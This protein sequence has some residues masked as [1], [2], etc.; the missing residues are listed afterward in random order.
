MKITISQIN[1]IIGDIDYNLKKILSEINKAK[2]NKSDV[3]LFPELCLCGYP[4]EDLIYF[5]G[6]TKKIQESLSQIVSTSQ[7]ILIVVGLVRK[8][9]NPNEKGFFNSAAVIAD[10]KLLGFKDKTLLPTYDVFNEKRYFEVGKDQKVFSYKGKKLGILICEDVWQHANLGGDIRY[11]RDPVEELKKLEP[12]V[13]LVLS[14]SPYYFKKLDLRL[15]I[16]SEAA[17]HL[18][19]CVFINNQVGGNDQLVFDGYSQIFNEK[20]EILKQAKGFE[21]DSIT[22]D[23]DEKHKHMSFKNDHI[24]DLYDALVLGVKDYFLKQGFS[25]A[26]LGLSGGIDSALTACI[27]VDALGKENV[28]AISMPSRFS[29]LSGIEDSNLLVK[30]LKIEIQ[31]M[32]IDHL[33]QEFL[34]YL[35]PVF[36]NKSFSTA[37]ENIQPRIRA[38]ILMAISNKLGHLLLSTGNKSEMALG[39]TTLYG[40]M[41]GGLGVLIDVTK[42]QV[43]ELA[44]WLNRKHEIIPKNII[45]KAPSAELRNNQKDIDDIPDYAII[46]NVLADYVEEHMSIEDIVKKHSYAEDLVRYLIKRIHQAEYKRRQGPIGIRVTKKSFGKGRL[47]PIVQKWM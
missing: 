2:E 10:E 15:K 11:D 46:D 35:S 47:F 34:N 14:A 31:H 28:L 3:I 8:N 27:A 19:C 17:K 41:C 20:G 24:K 9:I 32:P 43:Y 6:F 45:K 7:N 36:S 29:S 18:N 39:Y 21:E 13:V 40:D 16:Y 33:Y 4:P 37:E 38:I 5:E 30:K 12:D 25:K 42:T 1:P 23:L 26:C 22:I 44:K